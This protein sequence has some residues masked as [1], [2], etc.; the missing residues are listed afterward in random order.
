MSRRVPEARLGVNPR[1]PLGPES[2][3]GPVRH[4]W[5]Y[6]IA[7]KI[8]ETLKP[9]HDDYMGTQ[10]AGIVLMLQGDII[11]ATKLNIRRK[12]RSREGSFVVIIKKALITKKEK[13]LNIWRLYCSKRR[14][15]QG[16]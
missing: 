10:S 4:E 11:A 9:Y 12:S 13:N 14:G 7:P 6:R 1:V 8:I 2:H 15:G 5:F 16:P 3:F